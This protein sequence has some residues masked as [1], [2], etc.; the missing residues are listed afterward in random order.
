MP[1]V[2]PKVVCRSAWSVGHDTCRVDVEDDGPG[3]P[4]EQRERVFTAFARLDDSRT[5]ASGGYWPW[6]VYRA[7]DYALA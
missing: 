4:E 1:A 6:T 3:I 2:M 7:P 5:R